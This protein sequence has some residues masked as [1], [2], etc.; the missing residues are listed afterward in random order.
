MLGKLFF[1]FTGA[2]LIELGLLIYIGDLLGLWP[3]L[4][5]IVVTGMVGAAMARD[6][7]LSVVQR[8]QTELN[9]AKIPADAM[10][11]GL[12]VLVAGAFLITPGVITDVLGFALLIPIVRR[13]IKRWLQKRFKGWIEQGTVRVYEQQQPFG[14]GAT[15]E[16]KVT[17]VRDVD[18]QDPAAPDVKEDGAGNG[19]RAPSQ[20]ES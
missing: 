10:M 18:S 17:A 13:P 11:D 8:L 1:L 15:R 6:Q 16:G 19:D 5:L 7:G 4:A 2:T 3:T 12:C 20:N 9:A 14:R